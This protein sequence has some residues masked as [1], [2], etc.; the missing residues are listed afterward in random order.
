MNSLR[1]ARRCFSLMTIKWSRHSARKVLTTRS[2]TAFA[3]G[4]R[5]GVHDDAELEELSPDPLGAPQRVV[6]RH[7]GDQ[8]ADL[9]SKAK[10]AAA[11]A[12]PPGPVEPRRRPLRC[13]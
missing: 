13:Q 7:G 2:P 11:A 10:P 8:L 9:G 3:R 12:R 5:N 1:T 6:A 4:L